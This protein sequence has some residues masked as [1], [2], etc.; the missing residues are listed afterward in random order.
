[1]NKHTFQFILSCLAGG[2]LAVA[3]C[4]F[5]YP[6]FVSPLSAFMSLV[7]PAF[8]YSVIIFYVGRWVAEADSDAASEISPDVASENFLRPFVKEPFEV[9]RNSDSKPTSARVAYFPFLKKPYII[10]LSSNAPLM[11]EKAFLAHEGAHIALGHLAF[12]QKVRCFSASFFGASF[13][14]AF[15]SF[16]VSLL[17]FL[18]MLFAYACLVVMKRLFLLQ[19]NRQHEFEADTTASLWV[20][21]DMLFALNYLESHPEIGALQKGGWFLS[22]PSLQDRKKNISP[23][24][25][26]ELS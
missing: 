16:N 26:S 17:S 25:S 21:E 18:G 19:K 3:V 15:S 14:L 6:G 13:M 10:I 23:S 9:V 8:L 11:H 12:S 5:L 4:L 24:L 20:G 2:L 1:M 22:H 7:L